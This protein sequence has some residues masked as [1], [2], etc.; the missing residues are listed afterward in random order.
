MRLGID[1]FSRP[2]DYNT[3][4]TAVR[5]AGYSFVGKCLTSVAKPEKVVVKAELESALNHGLDFFFYY[6]EAAAR[7]LDGH[8]AG[9]AD[10]KEAVAALA[11][12]GLPATQVVYYCVD[13]DVTAVSLA[14][15]LAYFG[16]INCV[17]SPDVVGIYGDADSVKAVLDSG[18]ATYACQASAWAGSWDT[19]AQLHQHGGTSISG[20]SCD[21]VEQY[22]DSFGQVEGKE[23]TIE[24]L[25]TTR[26]DNL[27]M[28][29]FLLDDQPYK[30]GNE[31]WY[32]IGYEPS[33]DPLA[34][35]CSGGVYSTYRRAG[36]TFNG[37]ML[38]RTT[39]DGYWHMVTKI[40]QPSEV[41]DLGFLLSSNGTAHH[42][43]MYIGHG[44]TGEC[45]D[46]TGRAGIHDVP[47]QNNRG[48]KWGRLAGNNI[49][50]L[51]GIGNPD[52]PDMRNGSKLIDVR[53]LKSVMHWVIGSTLD[54]TNSNFLDATE[55]W[56]R[57]LQQ[58][59]RDAGYV[60]VDH[61]TPIMVNGV[62]NA[63]TE[64]AIAR[65]VAENKRFV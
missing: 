45:G 40:A 15:V 31:G 34:S 13:F 49:G 30:L 38:N 21:I 6:E 36:V 26:A 18:L 10:A 58:K 35:D 47:W 27:R 3:F 24:N 29:W 57:K 46:G 14:R 44:Q 17:V 52:W 5:L 43:F 1:Y 20:I 64:H 62:V 65:A 56:V 63:D 48:A 7:P 39:A 60:G 51:S 33:S 11:A 9:S 59:M 4:F 19:R 25:P 50:K 8:A 41:G 22:A 53:E 54:V 55:S 61:V 23:L 37:V 2:A 16:G 32:D 42:V 28:Q 12:L